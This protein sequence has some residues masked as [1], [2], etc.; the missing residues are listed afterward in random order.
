MEYNRIRD[1]FGKFAADGPISDFSRFGSGHIHDT[2][3]VRTSVP[4]SPGYILQR[5]N[6]NVFRNVEMLQENIVKVT[7]HIRKKLGSIPG[8]DP[9]REC[10]TPVATLRGEWWH[11]ESDGSCWRVF[12]FI[13]N[14][15]TCDR[16]ENEALALEGGRAVGKF[17]AMLSD[18]P[19]T[20]VGETIPGF[21][22][23]P[24][25]IEMFREVLRRDR[26]GRAASV[27]NETNKILARAD[28]MHTIARLGARG[29]I[30]LR[31]THNDTKFNNVLLDM[32]GRALCLIDLDT[33][34]PGYVH[35]DFGDAIRTAASTGDEDA[36]DLNTVSLSLPLYRAW[37]RGFMEES[38]HILTD[39]EIRWLPFAP[40]LITYE[41]A[42]RFL[43]DYIDGDIY[44]KVHDGDHNLRRARAQIK[45]L[46]SME[47]L[48]SEMKAA[49]ITG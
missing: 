42:L 47:E 1:I 46:E 13:D 30:P 24:Q 11:E 16:V 32:N 48:A 20:T 23:T 49:I 15:R 39:T 3:R 31:I 4:E 35:Y 29:A 34:M 40:G 17:V 6:T 44:Y 2:Y 21:H 36:S 12:I 5:I 22:N 10:L 26:A 7:L 8:S 38:R 43:A 27:K 18:M 14:H 9:L 19:G 37:V 33:V 28:E 45:L 41:Q 25:R